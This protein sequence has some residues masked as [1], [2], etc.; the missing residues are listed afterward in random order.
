MSARSGR[1]RPL[2]WLGS[3]ARS[4]SLTRLVLSIGLFLVAW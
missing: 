1:V 2:A 4:A 3:P